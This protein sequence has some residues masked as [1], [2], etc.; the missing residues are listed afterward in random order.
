MA[1]KLRLFWP[2]LF[3]VA[4]VASFG[5]AATNERVYFTPPIA[6]IAAG[7]TLSVYVAIDSGISLVHY[8]RVKVQFDRSILHLDTIVP[9]RAWDSIA[10]KYS[11][12]SFFYK[13]SLDPSSGE[14]YYDLFSA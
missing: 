6:A 2:L 14:R 7:D 4:V 9:S 10:L 12:H 1:C 13:D 5:Y 11:G 3:L 8:Y